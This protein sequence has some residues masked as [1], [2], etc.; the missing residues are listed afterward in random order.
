MTDLN[1]FSVS[2]SPCDSMTL[3]L[4]VCVC[5][6]RS[7]SVKEVN[8][9]EMKK[10]KLES[11]QFQNEVSEWVEGSLLSLSLSLLHATCLLLLLT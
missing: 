5:V 10:R 7:A 11:L 3:C 2:V 8:T 1:L 4:S 6:C 9:A